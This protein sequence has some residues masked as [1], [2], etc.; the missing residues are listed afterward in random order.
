MFDDSDVLISLDPGALTYD[1][2]D[3]ITVE[4]GIDVRADDPLSV[5][6]FGLDFDSD[7]LALRSVDFGSGLDVLGDGSLQRVIDTVPGRLRLVEVSL[8]NPLD[9]AAQQPDAFLF[10]EV[11]FEAIAAGDAAIAGDV[12][13]VA[14][15]FADLLSPAVMSPITVSVDQP[16]APAG[17]GEGIDLFVQ[18]LDGLLPTKAE[19]LVVLGE[20]LPDSNGD[21]RVGL[22][23]NDAIDLADGTV[24]EVSSEEIRDVGVV[25][26]AE[27]KGRYAYVSAALS[28]EDVVRLL[29]R[30]DA[31]GA[32]DLTAIGGGDEVIEDFGPE[33][34]VVLS[35]RLPDGNG[36]GLIGLG[37]NGVLDLSGSG[38]TTVA[39]LGEEGP[40]AFRYVGEISQPGGPGRFVYV[41]ANATDAQAQAAFEA[42]RDSL[43]PDGDIPSDDLSALS[44]DEDFLSAA[45][46][47]GATIFV[48]GVAEG[49]IG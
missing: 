4:V 48:P 16:D 43:A 38:D 39:F 5:L 1:I 23:R 44:L 36:D 40:D 47:L 35:A 20:A 6:E 8:D 13:V 34:A 29:D 18:D 7:L 22:G 31:L 10:A 9:L 42:A 26:A 45:A 2:G 49:E 28:D 21:G 11:E 27:D 37:G 3:R 41:G 32:A 24:I 12:G 30:I 33:D 46:S 25:F 19:D 17:G 15:A 14:D